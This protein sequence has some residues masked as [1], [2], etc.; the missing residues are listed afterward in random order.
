MARLSLKDVVNHAAEH[1]GGAKNLTETILKEALSFIKSQVEQGDEV[2]IHNFGVFKLKERAER[3]G[4]NPATG[5]EITIPASS[6]VGFKPT[7][8]KK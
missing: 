2:A 3:T 4:R 6:S 7:K 1:T 5:E 8:A